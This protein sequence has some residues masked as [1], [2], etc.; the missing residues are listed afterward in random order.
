MGNLVSGQRYFNCE[1][2]MGLVL[3]ADDV[4]VLPPGTVK[5]AVEWVCCFVLHVCVCGVVLRMGV[6]VCGSNGVSGM[7]D[8]LINTALQS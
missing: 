1:P 4:Q 5:P 8:G 6:I 2:C 7:I 3:N